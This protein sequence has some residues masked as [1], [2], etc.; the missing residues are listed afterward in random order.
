[1]AIYLPSSAEEQAIWPGE[2]ATGGS[3]SDLPVSLYI[4]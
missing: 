2:I 1:M 3:P 4:H